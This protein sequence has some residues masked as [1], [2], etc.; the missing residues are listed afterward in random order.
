MCGI[1]GIVNN[2]GVPVD[3]GLVQRMCETI[4]HRGPD[5]E[6]IWVQGAVGLGMRRLSIIDLAGGSQPIFNEDRSACIV[7]NGEIYNYRELRNDLEKRGYHFHTSSDTE[8][9]IHLYEEFGEDCVKHLRGMF[10]FAIWDQKKNVLLLGRDRLGKKPLYYLHDDKKLIFGSEIKSIL[11]HPDVKPEVY[12][13]GIVNY[14]AFGYSLDPDTLFKGISKL[15]PGH[16]LTWKNGRVTV[17]RYWD[18][19]YRPDYSKS[20]QQFLQETEELLSEAIRIRLMSEVPLG[21]FLSGGIDSSLVVALMALQM[22]EPVKTFSIGFDDQQYNE[23]PYA[24]MVANRYGTDHHEEIVRPDAETVIQYLIRMFD[25]PFAD[26]SAIPTYY[27]SK[28]ARR[29]VSVVLSGD[30]GDEIFGGYGSYLD[31]HFS[32]YTDRIP[33]IARQLLLGKLAK[34]L[35]EN[36]PGNYTMHYLAATQNERYMLKGSKGLTSKHQDVF[37]DNFT[38]EIGSTDPSLALKHYWDNVSH[39]DSLSRRQYLSIKTY[40]A[41]DILTKVDRASMFV[42]LEARA[43]MLDHKLVEFAATIPPHFRIH[44]RVTKYL[45][46]KLAQKYLPNEL[47]NRPKMGFTMPVAQWINREWREMS[48]DLVLSDRAIQRD[49]FNSR[50]LRQIV[51][52]HRRGRRDHS[53]IIWTLMVLEIWYREIID[54]K[55]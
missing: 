50:Y 3:V 44:E 22:G 20:E 46:K 39:L 11:Q 40:L 21:A 27:V 41:S 24:R 47:I 29:H 53:Y 4:W 19:E 33:Q 42:S 12:R 48:E 6:G 55:K 5:A 7:F 36:F 31:S 17:C 10:A 16:T 52:E 18:L 13:P 28:L 1:A 54:G 26:S 45:L 25:E 49:N 30:G 32:G 34:L 35:P 8:T 23:L 14:L 38:Q 51:N 37:S 15:P 2:S 9:I 43:P